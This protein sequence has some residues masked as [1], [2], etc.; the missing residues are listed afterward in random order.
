MAKQ[1]FS[2]L[3]AA[4]I[5]GRTHNVFY[6]QTQLQKL[7]KALITNAEAFVSAIVSDSGNT[8]GEAQIEYSLALTE[9]RERYVELKP[10]EELELEYAIA[11]GSDATE[12]R[13]GFGFVIIK[14]TADHTLFF[15]VV[16]PLSAAIAAGNCVIVQVSASPPTY[17]GQD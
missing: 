10:K 4:A 8:R 13:V 1:Q 2:P 6:R 7:H 12:R 3:R 5:D 11:K 14:A 15:S 16:A 17:M 9:L